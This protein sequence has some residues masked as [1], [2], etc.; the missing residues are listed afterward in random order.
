[1]RPER[2]AYAAAL[3]I[4]PI[5]FGEVSVRF[6]RIE[7]LESALQLRIRRTSHALKSSRRKAAPGDIHGHPRQ[8]WVGRA[9]YRL[10]VT[11]AAGGRAGG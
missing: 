2:A 4:D 3:V 11:I 1:M 5:V 6:I 8:R 10:R 7:E 9:G